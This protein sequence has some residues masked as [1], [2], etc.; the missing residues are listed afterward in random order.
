MKEGTLPNRMNNPGALLIPKGGKIPEYAKEYGAELGEDNKEG[1]MLKFP[2]MEKGRA[3]QRKNWEK[4]Y[5]DMPINDA[6]SKWTTGKKGN[7]ASYESMV[8]NAITKS[9]PIPITSGFGYRHGATHTGMHEGIDIAGKTGDAV[10]STNDGTVSMVSSEKNYGNFVEVDHGNGTKTRYAH[11][12]KTN[13]EVGDVLTKGQKLGEVGSTGRSS[14]P[15]L[16]YEVWKDGKRIDPTNT[17]S[18]SPVSSDYE[19]S[20][21]DK[22]LKET[23]QLKKSSSSQ[24][25]V[26]LISNRTNVINGSTT[27][28]VSQANPMVNSVLFDK[29]YLNLA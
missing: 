5:S 14:G 22:T 12:S 21:A 27:Y 10:V 11:L 20:A 13:V 15:H 2:T 3:A 9:G 16:H 23:S 6:L 26:A 4:N 8:N 29:Q 25:G 28:N 18:F 7:K 24:K 1:T 19:L 17:L